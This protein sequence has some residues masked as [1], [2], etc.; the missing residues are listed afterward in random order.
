AKGNTSK[1]ARLSAKGM[2]IFMLRRYELLRDSVSIYT[3]PCHTL[4][5]GNNK[6]RDPKDCGTYWSYRSE[7]N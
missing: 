3:S 6:S 5:T 2:I 4:V 7:S 1:T